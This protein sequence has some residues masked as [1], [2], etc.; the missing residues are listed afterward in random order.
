MKN[1]ILRTPM[2]TTNN[3]FSD[4]LFR[5]HFFGRILFGRKSVVSFISGAYLVHNKKMNVHVI[6][7]NR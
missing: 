1:V 3:S 5:T 7:S 6:D 2:R 4:A